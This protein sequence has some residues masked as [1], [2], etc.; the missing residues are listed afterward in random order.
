MTAP[1]LSIVIVTWNARDDV[2]RCL[3][4]VE[5]GKSS[6]DVE[7]VLV[8]NASS[9]DTVGAVR[10]CH[11]D[12]RIVED[13]TNRGFARANNLGLDIA[14]GR[15]VLLLNPDTEVGSETLRTCVETLDAEPEVG[16]VGCRLL[17]P[18]GSVQYECARRAYRL[19]HLVWEAFYLH[20]IFPQNRV[21]AHQLM[22]DWDHTGVRDVEAISGA[23]FMARREVFQAVARV[24]DTVFMYH[25]DLSLCLK[26]R[27]RGW[28][29]RFRGDVSTVHHHG[30]SAG[31]SSLA[32]HLLEGPVRVLLIQERVGR[33]GGAVARVLFAFRGGVRLVLSVVGR[34][35]PGAGRLRRER[36]KAF[37][38]R[39]HLDQIVWAL[40]PWVVRDRMPRATRS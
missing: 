32:L 6:L 1:D 14:C 25:E 15:H 35:I 26:I 19:T 36:P 37:D 4:A 31:R 13:S 21:F 18:D 7:V 16:A 11:P 30:R 2:L 5:S 3:D 34:L 17:Y 8:D 24:P 39:V 23:F 40:L 38:P 28:R 12:V 29:I 10:S 20:V 9:D 22:G 33:L 27:E